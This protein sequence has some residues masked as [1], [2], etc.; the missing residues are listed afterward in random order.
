MPDAKT[1]TGVIGGAR[2]AFLFYAL[3]LGLAVGVRL[4][5]PAL[6]HASLAAT[7]MTPAIAAT[8][9]LIFVAPESG[10][11]A[12]VAKLCLDSFGFRGWPLALGGPTVIFLVGLILLAALGLTTLAAPR[13]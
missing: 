3:A 13:I 5:A 8:I 2:D 10:L 9:M 1:T 4:V 7:M 11:R 12:S 6:G